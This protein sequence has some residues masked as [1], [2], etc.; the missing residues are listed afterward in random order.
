MT[1]GRGWVERDGGP[2]EV[3][4]PGDVVWFSLGEKTG[5]VQRQR[6]P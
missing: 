6:R 3:I 5:T 2:V 4:R 1:T